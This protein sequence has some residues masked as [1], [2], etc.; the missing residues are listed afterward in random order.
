MLEL[1]DK[2]LSRLRILLPCCYSLLVW[3]LLLCGSRWQKKGEVEDK[4]LSLMGTISK[5]HRIHLFT[6]LSS[7]LNHIAT[8]NC[9]RL[10]LAFPEW[11]CAQ[12]K[13][14]KFSCY[15][16]RASKLEDLPSLLY[17]C[18]VST[19]TSDNIIFVRKHY[20]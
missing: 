20:L 3:S 18:I 12:L 9:N 15:K 8:C 17:G 10:G 6:C 11:L 2:N 4:L 14:E 1:C 16:R 7:K 19:V 13:T 5:S